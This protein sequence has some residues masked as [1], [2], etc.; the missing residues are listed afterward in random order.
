MHVRHPTPRDTDFQVLPAPALE[1]FSLRSLLLSSRRAAYPAGMETAA[2]TVERVAKKRGP[3]VHGPDPGCLLLKRVDRT[4][5]IR[6]VLYGLRARARRPL[7]T[8]N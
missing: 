2:S 7:F 8:A 3:R 1:N 4:R 6:L 5:E